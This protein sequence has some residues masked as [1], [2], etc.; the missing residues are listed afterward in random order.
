MQVYFLK[1]F[2]IRIVNKN[3]NGES[4]IIYLQE[5]K[6]QNFQQKNIFSQSIHNIVKKLC[7]SSAIISAYNFSLYPISHAV[8]R[9]QRK[10]FT[11]CTSLATRER[12]NPHTPVAQKVAD[13]VVFRRFQGEGVEFLKSDLTPHLQISFFSEFHMKIMF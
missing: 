2:Q 7:Q 1:Q 9:A 5:K 4:S 13:E 10:Q 12:V 8:A 6:W 11:N 3:K